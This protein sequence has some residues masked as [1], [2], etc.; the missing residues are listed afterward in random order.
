MLDGNFEC[1]SSYADNVNAFCWNINRS[2]SAA[3]YK[4]A[5]CVEYFHL[6]IV[7]SCDDNFTAIADNFCFIGFNIAYTGKIDFLDIPKIF[8]TVS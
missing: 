1:L 4:L 3:V 2:V 5:T 8:P 6:C 7:N